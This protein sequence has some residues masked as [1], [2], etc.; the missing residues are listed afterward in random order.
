MPYINSGKNLSAR[1]ASQLQREYMVYTRFNLPP[2]KD[3]DALL[4]ML[5]VKCQKK[6][7]TTNPV[8]LVKFS[9]ER[10]SLSPANFHEICRIEP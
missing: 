7:D 3:G 2:E 5:E 1:Q 6:L 4:G 9:S 8:T 10:H